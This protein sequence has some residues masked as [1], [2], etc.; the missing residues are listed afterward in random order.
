MNKI[1]TF[2]ILVILLGCKTEKDITSNNSE[3]LKENQFIGTVIELYKKKTKTNDLYFSVEEKNYFIKFSEGYVSK[4]K[5]QKYLNKKILIK[6]KIKTGEWES[7]A[8]SSIGNNTIAPKPR[9]GD[10]IVIEKIYN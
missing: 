5:L 1:L 6:G 8:P 10:Y 7:M 2:I 3:N 9:S 4:E